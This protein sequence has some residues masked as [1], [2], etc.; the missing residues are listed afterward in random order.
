MRTLSLIIL[1]AFF[2][3]GQIN[4]QALLNGDFEI[5]SA[6]GDIINMNNGT[7]NST[8]SNT[9][10]FGSWG[11]GGAGGGNLDIITSTTYGLGPQS[12]NWMIAFTGGGTDQVT[13]QLNAS[14]VAGTNYSV[15][16]YDTRWNTFTGPP[17]EI[18]ITNTVG[19]LGTI[20]YT[21][22]GPVSNTQ[23]TLRTAN[24]TAPFN[25]LYISLRSQLPVSASVWT[26]VDNFSFGTVLP[27][28]NLSMRAE[29]TELDE[30]TV[31]WAV[32]GGIGNVYKVQ[33][34]LDGEVFEERGNGKV[35]TLGAEG[36][37]FDFVDLNVGKQGYF[38]R[39]EVIGTDG[40]S[41]FS[42]AVKITPIEEAND[43]VLYPNPASGQI[44][45]STLGGFIE[46]KWKLEVLDLQGKNIIE[47][48]G[49][50]GFS[51]LKI[52][53][54]NLKSGIYLIHFRN[55]GKIIARKFTVL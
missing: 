49:N 42:K 12:G 32:I 10:G 8:M 16:Y 33:R 45:L 35:G 17:M 11:G 22:P 24:F 25:A 44:M 48:V 1:T 53:L 41:F 28:N 38:Y 43:L 40:Q 6:G 30:V 50:T 5:N 37:N 15:T 2:T 51:E 36:W 13:M 46:G 31:E 55:Q 7:F 9:F 26:K 23:W 3:F 21:D 52:D 20:V 47:E 19:T 27:L 34:S 29:R 18:G 14:L 4:A 54:E 39:L